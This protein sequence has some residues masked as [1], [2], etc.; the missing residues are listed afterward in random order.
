MENWILTQKVSLLVHFPNA[1]T[2]PNRIHF[3]P[4]LHQEG[5]LYLSS[6]DVILEG[7]CPQNYEWKEQNFCNACCG[8]SGRETGCSLL[9]VSTTKVVNPVHSGSKIGLSVFAFHI[10]NVTSVCT[11]S[12]F[13]SSR[14]LIDIG[15]EK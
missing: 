2:F 15:R 6:S 1:P 8:K 13:V 14:V 5:I 10:C 9:W 11:V 4:L 12:P 3:L 7:S